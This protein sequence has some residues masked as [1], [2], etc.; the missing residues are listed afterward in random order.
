MLTH[1]L[2]ILPGEQG[3][4]GDEVVAALGEGADDVGEAVV[5]FVGAARVG[6]QVNHQQVSV[7]GVIALIL[8]HVVV[9]PA[10]A[11]IGGAGLLLDARPCVVLVAACA[12]GEVDDLQSHLPCP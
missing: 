10:A 12:A 7:E 8:Q 11:A 3:G 2:W 5:E 6:A 9:E 1:S 4:E